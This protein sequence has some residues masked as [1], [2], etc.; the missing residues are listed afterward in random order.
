VSVVSAVSAGHM[1]LS[2][3][4]VLATAASLGSI[5]VI[6][7]GSGIPGL[8]YTVQ[9]RICSGDG[10]FEASAAEDIGL[11]GT[12]VLEGIG[13]VGIGL[14]DSWVAFGRGPC[15]RHASSQIAIPGKPLASAASILER[16]SI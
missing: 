8:D 4:M 16:G 13:L 1:G 7:V 10:V 15:Q 6:A 14:V 2:D 9:H 12:V 11:E 3:M 5:Q